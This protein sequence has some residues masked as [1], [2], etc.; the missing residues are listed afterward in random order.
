MGRY[1]GYLWAALAAAALVIVLAVRRILR[2]RRENGRRP[3]SL[4]AVTLRLGAGLLVVWLAGMGC[5]TFA[6]AQ[7]LFDLLVK[8][9]QE[10]QTAF[11]NWLDYRYD[12]DL[13]QR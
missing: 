4:T 10:Y 2:R 11:S 7:V 3:A 8:D 9:A 1:M 5:A 6:T 13:P 12:E